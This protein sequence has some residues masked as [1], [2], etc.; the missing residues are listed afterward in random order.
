VTRQ[1][2]F[3]SGVS[4]L[5]LGARLGLSAPFGVLGVALLHA[6]YE[7]ATADDPR[8]AAMYLLLLGLVG[9]GALLVLPSLWAPSAEWRRD[10]Y[11]SYRLERRLQARLTSST[12]PSKDP[13]VWQRSCSHCGQYGAAAARPATTRCVEC[14]RPGSH[15]APT[16]NP[17]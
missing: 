12:E 10:E 4:T 6:L 13:E 17:R 7:A 5:G 14:R 9:V 8:P 16:A 3:G 15:G 11:A 1:M 2:K